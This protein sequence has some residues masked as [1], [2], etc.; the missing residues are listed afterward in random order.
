MEEIN[1]K[2]GKLESNELIEELTKNLINGNKANCI[3]IIDDLIEKEVKL[4]YLYERV[5]KEPLYLVGKLWED[6]KI[7]VA[8]E[9]LA[10]AI[11]E[12]LMNLYYSRLPY[13][14]KKQL[15]VIC[16]TVEN[17]QH[18]IGSRMVADI[19]EQNGWICMYLGS[20]ITLIDLMKYIE[21]V[22]PDVV[23]I[24]LSVFMNFH[25]LLHAL[26]S[27]TSKYSD[28]KIIVG[29]QAFIHGGKDTIAKYD[30]VIYIE[31]TE[32]LQDFLNE[33]DKV[34]GE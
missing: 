4:I 10:T 28:I 22:S 5:L 6:N 13:Q 8:K 2:T 19:F 14:D 32:K 33:S 31:N 24:S 23:A 26:D 17:E 11:T 30:N 9:H 1:I 18:Q 16:C 21:E 12:S 25:I 34:K 27:I 29:G 7:S 20:N 3:N 15:K